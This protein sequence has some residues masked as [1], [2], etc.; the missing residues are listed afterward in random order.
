M[1]NIICSA[2]RAVAADQGAAIDDVCHSNATAIAQ[3]V[4]ELEHMH[5]IVEDVKA[6]LLGANQTMQVGR[7][8]RSC[9][10]QRHHLQ[11]HLRLV[12]DAF[13]VDG[14]SCHLGA[15]MS[16]TSGGCRGLHNFWSAA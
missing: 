16:Q 6:S 3:T 5:S 9:S 14:S 15:S 13:K 7:S 11:P 1:V 8:A 12:A 4:A 10:S 2:L